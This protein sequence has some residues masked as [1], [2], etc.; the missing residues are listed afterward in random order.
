MV[1][2]SWIAAQPMAAAQYG[3][4]AA[5]TSTPMEAQ[6]RTEPIRIPAEPRERSHETR[7]KAE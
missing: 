3:I 4:P 6:S 1:V 5:M 7:L 2:S